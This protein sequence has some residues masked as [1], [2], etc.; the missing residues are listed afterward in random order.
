MAD[1]RGYRW[2]YRVPGMVYAHGPTVHYY[3]TESEVRKMLRE[4]MK[5]SRLPN[6]TEVW[7]CRG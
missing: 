3:R 6:G 2:Y 5:V 1:N 7:K 4:Y